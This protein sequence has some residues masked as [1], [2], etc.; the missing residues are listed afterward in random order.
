[1]AASLAGIA[2]LSPLLLGVA[3]LVKLQDR[4]PAFYRGVRVG[5]GGRLFRIYKFRTMVVD[6]HLRGPG[7]TTQG[8]PRVTP[9]GRWLRRTKLD[10]L[11]QLFNVLLGDMSLVGARPEDPRYVARYTETQREILRH[12]PGITSP[13]SLTFRREEELLAGPD[14]EQRYLEEVLPAKL[15][16]DRAYLERR[17]VQDDL[18]LIARTLRALLA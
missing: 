16:L 6:A 12:R 3:A 8:D 5:R 2:L 1:V 13:A 18:C 9:V 15:E 10:E 7:V 17:T 11:P 14:W 4:G